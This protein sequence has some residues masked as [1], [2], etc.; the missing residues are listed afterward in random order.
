M[1][2]TL[3]ITVLRS[4]DCSCVDDIPENHCLDAVSVPGSFASEAALYEWVA[5]QNEK[6]RIMNTF[7][8]LEKTV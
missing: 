2:P 7:I 8:V 6:R 3:P 4:S 5:T 1:N